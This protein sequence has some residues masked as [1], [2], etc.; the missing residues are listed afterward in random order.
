MSQGTPFAYNRLSVLRLPTF[1]V[2]ATV[3]QLSIT[4]L[5]S[6][7]AVLACNSKLTVTLL[8]VTLL[9]TLTKLAVATLPKLALLN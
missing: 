8:D 5:P 4:T 7:L 6:K 2:F 1:A 3:S 9:A